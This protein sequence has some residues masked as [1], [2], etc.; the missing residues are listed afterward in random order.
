MANLPIGLSHSEEPRDRKLISRGEPRTCSQGCQTNQL[1][2]QA[3]AEKCLTHFCIPA[4]RT[5][6][7]PDNKGVEMEGERDAQ[8]KRF[9]HPINGVY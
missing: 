4:P 6:L 5:V 2:D 7:A 9:I 3:L 1:I 8:R